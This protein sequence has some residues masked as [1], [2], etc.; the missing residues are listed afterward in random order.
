VTIYGIART[1]EPGCVLLAATDNRTYL[2][3]D[4]DRQTIDAGGQLAVTGH[5]LPA[6]PSSQ[7]RDG[8]PFEV[9]SVRPD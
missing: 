9:A 7:C 3:L 5:V 2:L 4:G 1:A 6:P 8:I